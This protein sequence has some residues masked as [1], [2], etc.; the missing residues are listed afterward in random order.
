[1]ELGGTMTLTSFGLAEPP[2]LLE[3]QALRAG[4]A[5]MKKTGMIFFGFIEN[6]HF[7]LN[8]K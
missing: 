2:S 6:L 3:T 7:V 8:L 5:R 1:M 4:M